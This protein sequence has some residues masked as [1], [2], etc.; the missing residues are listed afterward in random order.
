MS[1]NKLRL[2]KELAERIDRLVG[3]IKKSVVDLAML[4]ADIKNQYLDASGN[5][6]APEF[7]KFWISF[8]VNKKFGSR[9]NFSR[10]A[11]VGNFINRVEGQFTANA[12]QLPTT[13][14]ALYELAQLDTYELELCFIDTYR[15]SEVTS[16]RTKWHGSKKK[17]KPLIHPHVTSTEIS[18]W[19]KKW[20]NPIPPSADK[21]K[22]PLA[23]IKIHSSFGMFKNGSHK[24]LIGLE[25]IISVTE[26]LRKAIEGIPSEHIRLDLHDER[27]KERYRKNEVASDEKERERE[28][29]AKKKTTKKKKIVK[30]KSVERLKSA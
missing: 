3:N 7:E 28:A 6:Y 23:E 29:A 30:K 4:A 2:D 5:K 21:R 12:H 16:D 17:P 8:D 25:E 24:G 27:L 14:T 1:D 26:A 15:R 22:T 13:L 20:R 18:A 9:A 10:Y 19:R 11:S